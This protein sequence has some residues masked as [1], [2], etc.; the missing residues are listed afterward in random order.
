MA[1]TSLAHFPGYYSLFLKN[2]P[3]INNWWC[4]RYCERIYS[5][6]VWSQKKQKLS[7]DLSLLDLNDKSQVHRDKKSKNV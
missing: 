2:Q 3:H 5:H 4:R 1:K 6:C 7:T